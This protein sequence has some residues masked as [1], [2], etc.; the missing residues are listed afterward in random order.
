[1]NFQFVWYEIVDP[2]RH[3]AGRRFGGLYRDDIGRELQLQSFLVS[4]L[5]AQGNYHVIITNKSG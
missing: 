5:T 1:V 3:E 4:D 2:F